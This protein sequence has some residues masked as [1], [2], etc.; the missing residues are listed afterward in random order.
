MIKFNKSEMD[1]KLKQ[2]IEFI[3]SVEK[4]KKE[5]SNGQSEEENKSS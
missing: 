2:M 3:N 5:N 4:E 1:A